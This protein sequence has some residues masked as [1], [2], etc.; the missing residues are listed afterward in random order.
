MG[1]DSFLQKEETERRKALVEFA[2]PKNIAKMKAD[3]EKY[4]IHYDEWFCESILHQDG[5]VAETINILKEKGLTFEQDGA[6]WYRATAFGAEKDEVLVRKNGN[7]TYFAAE[8]AY[9]RNKFLKRGFDR[10]IDIWGADH[11]VQQI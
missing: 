5:E 9:H 8:I 6:L 2:L 4:R 11:L 3:M 1:S 7:P 10:C